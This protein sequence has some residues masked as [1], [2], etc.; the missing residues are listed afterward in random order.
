MAATIGGKATTLT[1]KTN[2]LPGGDQLKLSASRLAAP[3][4]GIVL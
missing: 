2:Q 1:C 4:S 3:L